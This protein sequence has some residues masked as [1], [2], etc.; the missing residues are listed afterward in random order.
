MYR[1]IFFNDQYELLTYNDYDPLIYIVDDMITPLMHLGC[2]IQE[3][4][5]DLFAEGGTLYHL[6]TTEGQMELLQMLTWW[7]TP[8]SQHQPTT[9]TY[10]T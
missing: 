5:G 8:T 3:R 1:A 4:T 2:T 10:N 7:G 6:R 9:D